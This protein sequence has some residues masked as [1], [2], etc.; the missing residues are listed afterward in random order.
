MK[1]S[2]FEDPSLSTSTS[3]S[4]LLRFYLEEDDFWLSWPSSS[5][6]K[7][8]KLSKRRSLSLT[9]MIDLASLNSFFLSF[10]IPKLLLLKLT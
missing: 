7:T 4:L 6:Y 1:L 3:D 8:K 2:F 10:K 9:L 5:G